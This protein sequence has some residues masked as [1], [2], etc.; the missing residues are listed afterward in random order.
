M[1]A[2]GGSARFNFSFY[3]TGFIL[4]IGLI[5]GRAV[6]A[7]LCPFGLVQELLHRI[8]SPKIRLPRLFRYL[9]YA[10]L[11]VFVLIM[12]VAD[13]NYAGIGDPSFCKYICPSGSLGAGIPLLLSHPE[14]RAVL[15]VLFSVKTAVL[16]IVL[17]ASVFIS[18]FFCRVICPLGALYGLTNR[19]SLLHIELD[20]NRCISCGCC[21][22][23]CPMDL[24]PVKESSSCECI[25]C[26]NCVSSCPH[27]AIRLH[28]GKSV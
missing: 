28:L 7:F 17:L 10:I 20:S 13:T 11:I 5:F 14:L 6:C 9:K 27:K 1:Q 23:Y 3:V 24:N 26:I 19:L 25:R 12:P 4:A 15:G 8:P 16:L 2:V 21:A 18:R 22:S